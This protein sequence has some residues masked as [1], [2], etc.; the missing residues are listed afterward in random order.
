MLVEGGEEVLA[1]AGYKGKPECENSLFLRDYLCCKHSSHLKVS[2]CCPY[3]LFLSPNSVI[4]MYSLLVYYIL[5]T[6]LKTIYGYHKL[7]FSK[8]HFPNVH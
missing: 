5:M 8:S 2:S 7:Y 1:R 6:L 3:L 4:Y